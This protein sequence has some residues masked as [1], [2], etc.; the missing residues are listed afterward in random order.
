[1]KKIVGVILI[2]IGLFMLF[3]EVR[4]SSFGFWHIGVV[5]TSAIV[6]VLMLLSAVAVVVK[7]NKITIGC[8]IASVCMLVLSLILGTRLHFA[9]MSLV[10]LLLVFIPIIIGLGIVI[11]EF[12]VERKDKG[13]E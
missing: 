3:K 13:N 6:L 10:D 9:Y 12:I 1:M 5:N 11:R 2:L 7:Q 8:L 4:V